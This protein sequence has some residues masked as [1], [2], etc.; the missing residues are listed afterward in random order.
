MQIILVIKIK[1]F[2]CSLLHS[3]SRLFDQTFLRFFIRYSLVL[4]GRRF[5]GL[6][7]LLNSLVLHVQWGYD[8]AMHVLC[9]PS[10]LK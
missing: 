5:E 2:S 8:R 9:I 6:R 7:E 3:F 10:P 1:S 4:I